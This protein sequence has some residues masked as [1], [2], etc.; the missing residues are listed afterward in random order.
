MS[1]PTAT[2]PGITGP[3]QPVLCYYRD[4]FGNPSNDPFD[5]AYTQVLHPYAVPLA[6]QNILT[7]AQVQTLALSGQTQNVPSAFLLQL[8][9][10]NLHIFLQL[11]KFEARMGLPATPWDGQLFAQ[12]GE[13][14]HNQSQ[15][16]MWDTSLFHQAAAP[17]LVG[18]PAAIDNA[19]AGDGTASNLGPH[20]P[21]DPDTELIRYRRTCYVPPAYVPLFLAG[22][23]TPRQAWETCRAQIVSDRKEQDCAP[24][25]DYLRAAITRS[26]VDQIPALAV[27]PPNPPLSDED[28]LKH[29]RRILE[30]DF[31]LL[32]SAQGTIQQNQIATQLGILIQDNRANARLVE[33]R[34]IESKQ[35]PLSNFIGPRGVA[36]LLLICN[37]TS[38]DQLP[39]LWKELAQ[40]SKSNQ[41][42]VLQFAVDETKTRCSEPELQFIVDPGML[43]LVKNVAFEMPSLD[44]LTGGL[45]VFLFYEKMEAEAYLANATYATLLNGTAGATTADLMP[46][47]KA[48]VKAPLSDMDVRHMHRRME[49]FTKTLFGDH[50][51]IPVAL[52][53]FLTRYL[54]MESTMT[55]LQLVHQENHLRHTMVCRKTSLA[56]CTWF[57][58][59]RMQSGPLPPPDFVQFFD[60]VQ[61]DRN[62]EQIVP[63]TALQQLGLQAITRNHQPIP[64]ITS[65]QAPPAGGGG[66]TGSAVAGS[67]ATNGTRLNNTAFLSSM[68]SRFKDMT[69]VS[70]KSLR[71]KIRD[72]DLPPLP[73][74]K[75]EVEKPVCLAWHTRAECNTNC[76]C[77]YDHVLTYT[78]AEC[79]PL[80]A[81]CNEN[82]HA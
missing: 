53:S 67:R 75:V 7:P 45:T 15:L 4:Y 77:K 72:G 38:E 59:R 9:D 41:L 50:H 5:G 79:Q 76:S 22:P 49:I 20:A 27:A 54:A 68:F 48:K 74:S 40:A 13:L 10:G 14:F 28:L 73:K 2:M 58:R 66:G 19:F 69:Q 33:E 56:L 24:L 17:L 29:R 30:N 6:N 42:S 44:S 82:F 23:V 52:E 18:T 36:L 70:C 64:S 26:V 63:S 25:I 16:V 65:P 78:A 51:P 71:D 80:L 57:R 39:P 11:A 3:A 8:A 12:K 37:V 47:I 34:R 1:H 81:W 55:R 31:P 32:N 46:L 60:D 62:W 43:Q 21:G 61:E 35:K